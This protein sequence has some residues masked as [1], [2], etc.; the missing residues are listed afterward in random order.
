M[1]VAEPLVWLIDGYVQ[2]FRAYHSMPDLRAPDGRPVGALRGYLSSLV[3]FLTRQRP[4]HV[5]VAWDFALT[6]FRNEIYQD[7]KRGRTEAPQDLATQIPL[8]A[9]ATRALGIPLFELEGFEA[10]DVIATLVRQLREEGARLAI[11]TTDKDLGVLVDARTS[12]FDLRAE[13]HLGAEEIEARFGVPPERLSD[14]LSLAGDAVDNIPGA[15]GIG[16]KTAAALLNHFGS[17]D[18]IPGDFAAWGELSLRGAARAHRAFQAAADEI[19][20]SRRLVALRD[21]LPLAPTLAD[22]AWTGAERGALES[23]LEETGGGALL[24]RVP[25]FRS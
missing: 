18:A 3:R 22:L 6:S 13:R 14:Y 21:D 12:L 1:A 8:C 7:Y 24:A 2:I 4:T 17:L 15:R 20:L 25:A 11:V 9:R 10:D 16:A 19:A 23:L 5:L